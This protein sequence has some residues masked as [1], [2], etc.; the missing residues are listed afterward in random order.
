MTDFVLSRINDQQLRTLLGMS[1]KT[2]LPGRAG[3]PE[4]VKEAMDDARQLHGLTTDVQLAAKLGVTK[5]SVSQWRKDLAVPNPQSLY[6]LA[7]LAQ[8]SARWLA[9]GI[10]RKDVLNTAQN[11]MSIQAWR[12][13]QRI[14]AMNDSELAGLQRLFSGAAPDLA[15]PPPPTYS[16]AKSKTK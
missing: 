11:S 15:V 5:Q 4:R 3:Y 7:D 6:A 13:A 8:C 10:G 14:A 16:A 9:L 2:S 12:L 1:D